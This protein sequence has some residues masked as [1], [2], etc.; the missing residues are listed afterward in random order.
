MMTASIK[1]FMTGLIAC[2]GLFPPAGLDIETAVRKDT[3]YLGSA[4]A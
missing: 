4:R 2:A 3:G 1:N